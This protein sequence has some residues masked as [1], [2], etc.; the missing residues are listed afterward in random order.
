MDV[1]LSGGEGSVDAAV[2]Y[3]LD[4]VLYCSVDERR[5]ND[6]DDD[7]MGRVGFC[8]GLGVGVRGRGLLYSRS[9]Y[10]KGMGRGEG[11]VLCGWF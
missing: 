11:L 5:E 10:Y 8:S 1:R 4:T 3:L 6:D 2:E 7:G 9:H